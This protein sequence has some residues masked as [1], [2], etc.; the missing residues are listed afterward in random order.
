MAYKRTHEGDRDEH[1]VIGGVSGKKV[2]ILDNEAN[3]IT[4]FGGKSLATVTKTEG[5]LIE[6]QT[7]DSNN[8]QLLTDILKELKKMNIQLSLMTDNELTNSELI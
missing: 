8:R 4:D 2:F 3:Q 1:A 7:S 6:L 5:S